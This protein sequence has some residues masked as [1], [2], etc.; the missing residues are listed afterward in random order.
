MLRKNI[1]DVGRLETCRF[2]RLQ[3]YSNYILKFQYPG[4]RAP[5]TK[6]QFARRFSKPLEPMKMLLYYPIG[7]RACTQKP[8]SFMYPIW[9][10]LYIYMTRYFKKLH[11]HPSS[12]NSW[13]YWS[14]KKEK[15]HELLFGKKALMSGTS[16]T[17]AQRRIWGPASRRSLGNRGVSGRQGG[18]LLPGGGGRR[19]YHVL[20]CR[21]Q[22]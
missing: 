21:A 15:N 17:G 19:N 9:R 16:E 4:P 20:C 2:K 8:H 1:S 11:V 10:K 13:R 7:V 5:Y 3:E 22:T 12:N 18:C 14:W 6:F